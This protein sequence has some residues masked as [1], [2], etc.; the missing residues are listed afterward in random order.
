MLLAEDDRIPKCTLKALYEFWVFERFPL[1]GGIV[2]DPTSIR[3]FT[4]ISSFF[5]QNKKHLRNHVRHSGTTT[6]P[7]SSDSNPHALMTAGKTFVN[8]MQPF[9]SHESMCVLHQNASA[10]HQHH[11]RRHWRPDTGALPP[12]PWH[13]IHSLR[14]DVPC[15]SASPRH[16]ATR[17][18][19]PAAARHS[20]PR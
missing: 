6:K 10:A 3:V 2:Y 16:N 9:S 7:M 11:R 8:Q 4:R 1:F 15:T 5:Q 18:V 12:Q 19:L 17:I 20:E 13:P 14:E